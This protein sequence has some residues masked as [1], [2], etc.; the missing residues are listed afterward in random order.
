MRPTSFDEIVGQN[1]AKQQ[2]GI[3]CKSSAKQNRPMG[4][5]CFSG[6]A[7]TGKTTMA[8]IVGQYGRDFIKV[9]GPS[10]QT[11]KDLINVLKNIKGKDVLFVDEIHELSDKV[12]HILYP[13]MEDFFYEKK[14][15]NK[16]CSVKLPEFTLIGATTDVGS[17]NKPLRD[18][19]K[20]I[21][22]F[23]SYTV[24][25][26]AIL[27]N[28]T[29]KEYAGIE[30]SKKFAEAVANT[31]KGN[32]RHAISRSEWIR[33]WIFSQDMEPKDAAMLVNVEKLEEILALQGI[34]KYGLNLSEQQ[35]LEVLKSGTL[36]LS[37]LT[38]K[39]NVVRD[40]II[41]DIEPHL[42]EVGLV[43]IG[44]RGRS[45]VT[46]KYEEMYGEK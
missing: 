1:R 5:I 22:E 28:R 9:N 44:S 32:P 46:E 43:E 18:R 16:V 15:G 33:D 10:I 21:V 6:R 4:H 23:E 14:D 37:S 8:Q 36:S 2:L 34:D 19:F 25:E 31:C 24:E 12:Q 3:I 20:H 38:S 17:L 45:L 26:L 42:I 30:F 29:A 27:V 39:L 13:V 7:G 41:S 11:P 35:Y 40:N